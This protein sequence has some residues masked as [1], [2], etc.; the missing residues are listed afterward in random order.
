VV[1]VLYNCRVFFRRIEVRVLQEVPLE[2]SPHL[3]RVST[4]GQRKW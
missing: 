2:L 1:L 4:G 3:R